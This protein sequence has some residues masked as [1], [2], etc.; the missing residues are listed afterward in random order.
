MKIV[1]VYTADGPGLEKGQEF[2]IKRIG[3]TTIGREAGNDIILPQIRGGH[4]DR[5]LGVFKRGLRGITYRDLGSQ[6]GTLIT[7]G[8]GYNNIDV[9]RDGETKLENGNRLRLGGPTSIIVEA[10]D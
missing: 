8:E 5:E 3:S 2:P 4:I 9:L 1:V 7:R 6:N 10:Q